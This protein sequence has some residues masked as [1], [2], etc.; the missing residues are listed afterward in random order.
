M[1]RDA[2]IVIGFFDKQFFSVLI[3]GICDIPFLN[4]TGLALHKLRSAYFVARMMASGAGASFFGFQSCLRIGIHFRFV[5][6]VIESNKSPFAA[7]VQQNE[8]LDG[9]ITRN[10]RQ[11][12]RQGQKRDQPEFHIRLLMQRTFHNIIRSEKYA[13][14]SNLKEKAESFA[15]LL[16]SIAGPK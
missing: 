12:K 8:L 6:F 2:K 3:L 1:T 13:T 9:F 15:A 7:T 16:L 4:M 10:N 5:F 14:R 11:C